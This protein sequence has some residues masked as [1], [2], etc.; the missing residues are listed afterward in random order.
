MHHVDLV[1]G[2][3]R[4]EESRERGN[5]ASPQSASKE[6][7]LRDDPVEG[8]MGHRPLFRPSTLVKAGGE[9]GADLIQGFWI[10]YQR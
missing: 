4:I 9:G 7:D 10:E 1:M 8:G 5:E 2:E 3:H 6:S